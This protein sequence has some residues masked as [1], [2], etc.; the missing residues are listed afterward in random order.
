[1]LRGRDGLDRRWWA[2]ALLAAGVFALLQL[3]AGP[4]VVMNGDSQEY[5]RLALQIT[6]MPRTA[7]AEAAADAA[8]WSREYAAE[9]VTAVDPVRFQH[10]GRGGDARVRACER[11]ARA[12]TGS[13]VH[14]GPAFARYETIFDGRIGYPLLAVPAVWSFGVLRGLWITSVLCT[15][16]AGFLVAALLAA[17]GLGAWA[18]LAGELLYLCGPPGR[19]GVHPLAE[20]ALNAAALLTLLGAGWLLQRRLGA[21][22]LTWAAGL[23]LV[24]LVKYSSG[25]LLALALLVAAGGCALTV[26]GTRHL[27]TALLAAGSAVAMPATMLITSALGLPGLLVTVQDTFTRHFHRPDVAHPLSMLLTLNLRFWGA[28]LGWQAAAPA[29]LAGLAA[30]LFLLFRRRPQLGWLAVAG[31]LLGVLTVVA[32]PVVYEYQRLGVLWWLPAVLGLPLLVEGY[33]ALRR[34]ARSERGR[35]PSPAR[36]AASAQPTRYARNSSA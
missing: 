20:G 16:A 6:G 22:L 13:F 10:P 17:S 28:F 14:P 18:A 25:L 34:R 15:A 35:G 21:G 33:L 29:L 19:W 2:V 9:R 5:G 3:L 27:G 12:A 4:Q 36:P 30:G 11:A 23:V 32:H 1:V 26:R 8:C 7:A 24:A 31:T